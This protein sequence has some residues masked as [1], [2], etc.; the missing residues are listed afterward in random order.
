[1]QSKRTKVFVMFKK[2]TAAVDALGDWNDTNEAVLEKGSVFR[3]IFGFLVLNFS[4]SLKSSKS[5]LL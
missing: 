1:M 3:Q 2:L 5:N 4:F